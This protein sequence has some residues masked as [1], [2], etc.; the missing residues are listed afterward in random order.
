MNNKNRNLR[1]SRLWML[2]CILGIIAIISCAGR[3]AEHDRSDSE[4]KSGTCWEGDWLTGTWEG[5]TPSSVEPF[6][7][8]K[9][10]IVFTE[11]ELKV[12][13][14]IS[15]NPRKIWAYDGVFT[16]DAGGPGEF[17]I[18][19]SS[20]NWS[21][22][23]EDNTIIYEC[24]QMKAANFGMAHISLRIRGE[25]KNGNLHV[26]N[27]D[28]GPANNMSSTPAKSLN[29]YGDIEIDFSG[30][31]QSADYWQSETPP[32]KMEKK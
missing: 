24:V 20:A 7:G 23:I 6:A 3:V 2:A 10:R 26:F 13:N 18:N 8:T 1:S 25:D 22:P 27:L 30:D 11:A 14:E 28:W 19:F 21:E 15:G 9:I 5:T 4:A 29:F 31:L 12:D 16:W 32:L 17:S